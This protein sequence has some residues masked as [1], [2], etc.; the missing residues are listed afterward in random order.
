VD[1]IPNILTSGY[2]PL[3]V[4]SS[5]RNR[6]ELQLL[7]QNLK[8]RR[9][10]PSDR[11]NKSFTAAGTSEIGFRRHLIKLRDAEL[12]I[13]DAH[14]DIAD[15]EPTPLQQVHLPVHEAICC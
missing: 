2:D 12:Q 3:M 9:M 11:V 4:T 10:P 13:D 5:I 14:M 6:V 15:I 7:R 8:D 1:S